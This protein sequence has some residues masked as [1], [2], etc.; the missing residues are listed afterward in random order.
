MKQGDRRYETSIR[1]KCSRRFKT[2]LRK[3]AGEWDA[4]K[5]GKFDMSGVLRTLG[6]RE[7]KRR[8]RLRKRKREAGRDE[9]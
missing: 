7:I 2:A 4:E 6:E 8:Q 9:A 5:A 1:V 3:V